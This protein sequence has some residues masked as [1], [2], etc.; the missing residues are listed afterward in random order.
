MRSLKSLNIVTFCTVC[1]GVLYPQLD[2][3]PG[4]GTPNPSLNTTE[5]Q[6]QLQSFI[7][8]PANIQVIPQVF[9]FQ[10]PSHS[11][12]LFPYF[13]MGGVFI[14]QFFINPSCQCS[15][16]ALQQLPQPRIPCQ[17]NWGW[18]FGGTLTCTGIPHLTA[19]IEFSGKEQREQSSSSS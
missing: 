9:S 8:L 4:C 2:V 3:E 11:S 1:V 14:N 10:F 18:S 5:L 13:A 7:A 15:S 16:K 19:Q 6:F 17:I 12:T